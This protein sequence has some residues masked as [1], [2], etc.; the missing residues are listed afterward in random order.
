MILAHRFVFIP[1]SSTQRLPM[2]MRE[3]NEMDEIWGTGETQGRGDPRYVTFWGKAGNITIKVF[4]V[5]VRSG[6]MVVKYYNF[7][8]L[9]ASFTL[10][11]LGSTAIDIPD[12]WEDTV[13]T[14]AEA[15]A[16][17]RVG[18]NQAVSRMQDFEA[19]LAN[20]DEISTLS[21]HDQA[22]HV[23]ADM[24]GFMGNP[25]LGGRGWNNY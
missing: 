12:G 8:T 14:Y 4:P 10:P 2:E 1:T 22:G 17:F 3:E 7:P 9:P 15:R 6:S 11:A 20:Y 23:V 24:M 16:R 18:D 25:M 5:P 21:H 13:V 19:E